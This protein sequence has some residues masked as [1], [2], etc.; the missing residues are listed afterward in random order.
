MPSTQSSVSATVPPSVFYTQL[1]PF[2]SSVADADYLIMC[3]L[4]IISGYRV[5]FNMFRYSKNS[6]VNPD[7]YQ[8]LQ[9]EIMVL[10]SYIDELQSKKDELQSK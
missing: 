5:L 6:I 8:F 9:R 4:D 1:L 7:Y 10:S 3:I 2:V